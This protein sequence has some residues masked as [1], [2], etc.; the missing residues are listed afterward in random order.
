MTATNQKVANLKSG[1]VHG[2]AWSM[3]MRWSLK[4]LGLISTV[5]LARILTPGDYGIV[6]MA[7]LVVGLTEVLVDFGADTNV[8][9]EQIL[10]RDLIDSAWTLSIIQGGTVAVLLALSAPLAEIYFEEPRVVPIIWII[11]AFLFIG[12]FSNI[13]MTVARK[14]LQ[15]GLEFRYNLFPKLIAVI[16][17]ISAALIIKDY[18]ALV[19]GIVVGIVSRLILSYAMHP[20][21]PV[22]NTSRLRSM[23]HFSK[24]LL[25]SGIANFASRKSDEL[26]AGRIGDAH[27]L[28]IYSV[29]SEIGQMPTAELGPP[30]MRAFLPILSTIKDD[31]T[32]VRSVVLK[33]LGAVNTLTLPAAFGF[34]AVAEPL[35]AILL[36]EKWLGVA[37]FLAIFALVGALKVAVSPFSSLFLLLGLS[38]MHARLMWLELLAFLIAAAIF[39]PAW[40]VPGLAYARLVSAAIYFIV[41]LHTT[42]SHT[43]IGYLQIANVLWRPIAGASAMLIAISFMPRLIGNIFLDLTIT[44]VFGSILYASFIFLSWWLC[45]QPDSIETFALN[46]VKGASK[47]IGTRTRH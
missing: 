13:G 12:S 45:K 21:R 33:T 47:T 8:L 16:V 14:E 32:R 7:M 43:G 46:L 41:N 5:I 19:L 29:A 15:F 37:S 11:A 10:T 39:V 34:A 25:I 35:T 30:I 20:Y 1:F 17:T 40:G 44:I 24:W 3:G 22:W 2:A 36:G 42:K 31:L 4:L 9:R 38:K 23:W 27:S 26:I 18:R 6:A 28:G